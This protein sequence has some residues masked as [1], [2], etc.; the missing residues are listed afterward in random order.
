MNIKTHKYNEKRF[1]SLA[2]I[3]F[4]YYGEGSRSMAHVT[5]NLKTKVSVELALEEYR[6]EISQKEAGYERR[7]S[8]PKKEPLQRREAH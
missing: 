3:S 6:R 8:L 1:C 2:F 7:N 4:A 5:G